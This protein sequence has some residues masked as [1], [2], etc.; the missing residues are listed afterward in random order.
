[1]KAMI[2]GRDLVAGRIAALLAGEGVDVAGVCNLSQV[3][4]L[5][6]QGSVDLVVLDPSLEGSEL[7]SRC[8]GEFGGASAVVAMSS[9]ETDWER[10]QS[11]DFDGYIPEE[12]G[13]AETVARI[14]A[15]VRRRGRTVEPLPTNGRLLCGCEAELNLAPRHHNH[16]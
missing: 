8:L 11:L 10:L 2:F 5:L 7:L 6:E 14:R 12:A 9:S 1:M 3:V 13:N 4:A 16:S 15:V